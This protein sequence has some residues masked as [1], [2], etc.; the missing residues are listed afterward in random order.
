MS[1]LDGLLNLYQMISNLNTM[2]TLN[3]TGR[4]HY[5]QAR[6]EVLD[7]YG[8]AT[9]ALED[10][11]QSARNAYERAQ[12][13]LELGTQRSKEALT[14]S[15]NAYGEE[16]EQGKNA[17]SML[18]SLYGLG[19]ATRAQQAQKTYQD[20]PYAQAGINEGLD[21]VMRK[22]SVRGDLSG[23]NTTS[24]L[25]DFAQSHAADRMDGY[26]KGLNSLS[27]LYS[28]GTDGLA[29]AAQQEA[30]S[31]Q[32]LGSN[33]SNLWKALANE[34]GQSYATQASEAMST[35]ERQSQID[36]NEAQW[37]QRNA[38]GLNGG[39]SSGRNGSGLLALLRQLF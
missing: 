5:G 22:A 36:Q 10:G 19:G 8:T 6:Q 23:G 27:S 7:G 12:S 20:S 24:E 30:Q 3:A 21:A 31:Y 39:Y 15:A 34:L 18:Q 1:L 14:N 37:L 32:T 17:L 35:A 33:Q 29:G 9:S 16:R 26:V 11:R 2:D 28:R 13:A 25:Y 4:N 38:Q